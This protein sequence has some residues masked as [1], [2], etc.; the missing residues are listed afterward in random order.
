MNLNI[1]FSSFQETG[2]TGTKH[3][4]NLVQSPHDTALNKQDD[5][6]TLFP[7]QFHYSVFGALPEHFGLGFSSTE[8]PWI[9][10]VI[11]IFSD[12]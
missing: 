1:S 7:L 11:P 10:L 12:S 8:K 6:E 3:L 2:Q 4:L 9:W 5:Q